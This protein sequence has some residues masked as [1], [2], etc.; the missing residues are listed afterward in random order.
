[1]GVISK[2]SVLTTFIILSGRLTPVSRSPRFLQNQA[3]PPLP[4]PMRWPLGW[5]WGGRCGG[6][7]AFLLCDDQAGHALGRVGL[8]QDGDQLS[9]V[10]VCC[11]NLW[12]R[13]WL[14]VPWP[15]VKFATVSQRFLQ[16]YCPG[17]SGMNS[18]A[19]QSLGGLQAGAGGRRGNRQS[20]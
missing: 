14:S 4:T 11:V 2:R 16:T 10:P 13:L 15:D 8:S 7:W 18:P 12:A 1:M 19:S 20:P 3:F 6:S 5:R 9:L 17:N